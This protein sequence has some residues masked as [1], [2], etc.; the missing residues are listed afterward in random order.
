MTGPPSPLRLKM[1][2]RRSRKMKKLFGP[3]V[4]VLFMAVTFFAAP[5]ATAAPVAIV[6][7][8]AWIAH[9]PDMV[10]ATLE[11][12]SAFVERCDGNYPIRTCMFISFGF[13]LI[14]SPDIP[15]QFLGPMS[16]GLSVYEL[17]EDISTTP[18]APMGVRM[19]SGSVALSEIANFSPLVN[20]KDPRKFSK[21]QLLGKSGVISIATVAAE[22]N[23]DLNDIKAVFWECPPAGGI[24]AILST[25]PFKNSQV[26]LVFEGTLDRPTTQD[27]RSIS[28]GNTREHEVLLDV[29]GWTQT[30]ITTG[31]LLDMV[32]KE[33]DGYL[34]YHL[35]KV[36]Y[37]S[38]DIVPPTAM[39]YP[40]ISPSACFGGPGLGTITPAPAA[41]A[42]MT[43]PTTASV[44]RTIEELRQAA[45]VN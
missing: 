36:R 42:T 23:F 20:G 18:P 39:K 10:R 30:A 3:G 19:A 15:R 41:V 22:I 27:G 32:I 11:E 38:E 35:E 34:S 2:R 6:P 8:T 21:K 45:R 26:D 31:I 37:P 1:E 5:A 40:C 25:S 4:F 24:C 28:G 16:Q 29:R 12:P 43:W 17:T 33:N 9:L 13:S 14:T 7:N 44:L